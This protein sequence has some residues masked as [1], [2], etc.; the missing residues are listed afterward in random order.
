LGVK[1][2]LPKDGYFINVP[3][4]MKMVECMEDE[5]LAQPKGGTGSMVI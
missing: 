3:R 5:T 1:H 2:S 4:V